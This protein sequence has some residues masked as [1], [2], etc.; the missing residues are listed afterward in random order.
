MTATRFYL[1]SKRQL[2]Y[3]KFN[4]DEFE[5][6]VRS[7]GLDAM[8]VLY[9]N[10]DKKRFQWDDG[11]T[12][13]VAFDEREFFLHES[14]LTDEPEADEVAEAL[15][16]FCETVRECSAMTREECCK[17]YRDKD[18]VSFYWIEPDI[19]R[20]LAES[21]ALFLNGYGVRFDVAEFIGNLGRNDLIDADALDELDKLDEP[22]RFGGRV[23]L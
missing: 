8:R 23:W 16:F 9:W 3:R 12:C 14:G 11:A 22:H 17:E 2:S 6:R 5:K 1:P 10:Y 15:S 19:K 18:I 7:G 21:A 13:L 4:V 20:R